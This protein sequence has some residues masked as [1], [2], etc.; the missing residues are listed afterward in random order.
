[1]IFGSFGIRWLDGWRAS[2]PWPACPSEG[3]R[4]D[5]IWAADLCIKLRLPCDPMFCRKIQLVKGVQ[6]MSCKRLDLAFDPCELFIFF[7]FSF[8]PPS[9]R[10]LV[11]FCSVLIRWVIITSLPPGLFCLPQFHFILISFFPDPFVLFWWSN[12]HSHS[13]CAVLSSRTGTLETILLF[14]CCENTVMSIN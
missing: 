3:I 12:N 13:D 7:I 9:R 2:G 5:W 11:P 1:M 6:L 14:Y 4:F 10:I 8:L